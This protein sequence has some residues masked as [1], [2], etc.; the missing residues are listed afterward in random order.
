MSTQRVPRQSN[1]S[2]LASTQ[3]N[4]V[5]SLIKCPVG[6]NY[7]HRRLEDSHKTEK[8]QQQRKVKMIISLVADC[9]YMHAVVHDLAIR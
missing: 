5:D 4:S 1:G 9:L 8:V 7:F 3:N 2:E 6:V